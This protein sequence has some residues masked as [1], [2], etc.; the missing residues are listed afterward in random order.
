MPQTQ[1]FIYQPHPLS[2]EARLIP[3]AL[4]LRANSVSF[5]TTSC[6]CV[7]YLSRTAEVSSGGALA[8]SAV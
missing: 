6:W 4:I 1:L 8:A 3:I 7:L 5:E 2:V